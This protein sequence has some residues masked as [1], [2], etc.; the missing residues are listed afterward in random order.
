MILIVLFDILK[1]LV[2]VAIFISLLIVFCSE[3]NGWMCFLFN[4]NNSK[5]NEGF[6]DKILHVNRKTVIINLL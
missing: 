3:C 4:L 5:K 1:I 2:F 6:Y